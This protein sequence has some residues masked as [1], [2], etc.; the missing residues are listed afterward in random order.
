LLATY[1]TDIAIDGVSA[2]GSL[3]NALYRE[4][5]SEALQLEPL[6]QD[7]GAKIINHT[8]KGETDPA[9]IK[10]I[11]E[12]AEGNPF[13]V[14]EITRAML[15]ADQLTQE[16]G[17]WRLP[18]GVS[19]QVPAELRELL[20]E[21]V[22]RLGPTVESTLATAAVVGRE[23]RFAVLRS[24]T[25]LPDGELFDALDAA[26]AAQLIEETENG[27]RFQHS[28]IRHTLYDAF[29]RRRRAWL[30][31][32]TGQV[33]E[34]IYAG[35]PEG[36]TPHVEAL[37]YHYDLSDRRDK[38]LPYLRQAA[39]KAVNLF[40]I[41][42]AN[43]YLER[44]L[45]LMDELRVND[46][47]QRWSILEQLG[48]LAKVLADTSRAVASYEQALALSFPSNLETTPSSDSKRGEEGWQPKPGD[49][50]RLHR[51]AARSLITAGRGSEAERHLQTAMEVMAD[52][53]QASPDYANLLYDV[54][55]WHWHNNEHQEAFE[56]AQR[57]LDIAEQLNDDAAR[58]QAYEMLALACHSLGE[59]QQGLNFEQQRSTL[60]GPNLDVT[61]AFDAH[62]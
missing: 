27:Y 33:I 32:R 48:T 62:L 16:Q 30:H 35:R 5:L 22:Q 26:L 46:P 25:E 18:P 23:F 13:F 9:L 3:L 28:L 53:G 61:E 44:A 43:D 12:V 14:Q 40:A 17:Q 56:A 59:W 47:A 37:A 42:V 57:S 58:A 31:T 19:M 21:R 60:I 45:T 24:I 8:L 4:G 6:S 7:A 39:R 34:A 10:A 41:E 51:S 2:F 15:K 36:L 20:R 29:S 1:R 50:V 54:A 49:R 52:T 11:Y 38:A 55:L